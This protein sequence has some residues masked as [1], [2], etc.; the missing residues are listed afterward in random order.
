MIQ[1]LQI[2]DSLAVSSGISSVI[3]GWFNYSKNSEV[4]M[5][6][7]CSWKR[8]PSY[9]EYVKNKGSN[10]WYISETE[11]IKNFFCFIRKVDAFFRKHANEYDIVHLH[12]AKCE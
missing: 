8:G 11:K 5:D 9:D 6:F 7:L 1:V 2:Y 3:L 10:V 12:S 4:K